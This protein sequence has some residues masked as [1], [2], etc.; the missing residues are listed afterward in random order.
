MSLSTDTFYFFLKK[1]VIR[2][3]NSS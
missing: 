1:T 2:Y 3:R